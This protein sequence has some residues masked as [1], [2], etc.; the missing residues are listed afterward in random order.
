MI[1]GQC[2]DSLGSSQQMGFEKDVKINILVKEGGYRH[3]QITPSLN[4][5]T[6]KSHSH[7]ESAF[8][9]N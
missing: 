7:V 6:M 9:L 8:P 4:K 2:I 3:L 5:S 1:F